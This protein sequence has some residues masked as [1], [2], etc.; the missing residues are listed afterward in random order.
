[1][2]LNIGTRK[3]TEK[4]YNVIKSNRLL[5]ILLNTPIRMRSEQFKQF[6]YILAVAWLIYLV[7]SITVDVLPMCA[8]SSDASTSCKTNEALINYGAVVMRITQ[9]VPAIAFVMYLL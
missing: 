9:L 3:K 6:I 2:K 4:I 1:V 5:F 8:Q 7:L